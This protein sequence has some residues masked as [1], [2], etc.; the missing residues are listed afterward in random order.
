MEMSEIRQM[1]HSR[2]VGDFFGGSEGP[3]DL[4]GHPLQCNPVLTK[5]GRSCYGAPGKNS[6]GLSSPRWRRNP[7]RAIP[8]SRYP[9][10][11]SVGTAKRC[12]AEKLWDSLRYFGP[13]MSHK[14]HVALKGFSQSPNCTESIP[15]HFENQKWACDWPL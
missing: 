6:S 10:F 12:P 5:G 3:S 4:D 7:A 13:H 14:Q 11:E 8:F 1:R 15:V 9:L 2:W